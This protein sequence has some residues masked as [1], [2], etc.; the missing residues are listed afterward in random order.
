V[1][2]AALGLPMG[3]SCY[4]PDRG[5]EWRAISPRMTHFPASVSDRSARKD[6][7]NN[8]TRARPIYNQSGRPHF[9]V[10]VIDGLR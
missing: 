5:Q 9:P 4:F 6:E 1:S 10:S 7:Q 2:S 3:W 8:P